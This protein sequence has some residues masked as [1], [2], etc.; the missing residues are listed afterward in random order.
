MILVLILRGSPAP[1]HWD[2]KMY[3]AIATMETVL[4]NVLST[5]NKEQNQMYPPHIFTAHFNLVTSFLTDEVAKL[6]PT[7]QSI[8][9]IG[10]PFLETKLIPV[11]SGLVEFPKDYRHL[12]GAG[13]F[14]SSDFQD[15]CCPDQAA[16]EPECALPG[17]PLAPTLAQLKEQQER[18]KCQ[19]QSVRIVDIAEFDHL[20]SHSYKFPSLRKP[21]GCIFR[22]I[23]I[24][25]CPFDVPS[26]ELR[27]IRQP[28]AA[29]YGYVMNP[30]DTYSFNASTTIESEWT[31]NAM[32]YLV[33][34][35]STLYSIYTRD[36]E[37]RDGILELKRAGI[38]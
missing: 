10:R 20:T 27:Y 3:M 31:D 36:G 6:F 16:P 26:V 29:R 35:I 15:N 22:G 18:G 23:G 30:D 14:V 21:L 1:Y 33:K 17:D 28:R 11:R 13:I 24:K 8:I 38:F 25:I 9:D 7:S 34:G 37:L 5:G 12:I 32:Q 19:S 2:K 4:N